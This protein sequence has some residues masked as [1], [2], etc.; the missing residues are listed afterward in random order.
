MKHQYP[1]IIQF[2]VEYLKRITYTIETDKQAFFLIP[3][4]RKIIPGGTKSPSYIV[5]GH[6]MFESRWFTYNVRPHA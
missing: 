3:F 2:I 6:M 1:A 5:L 4:Y